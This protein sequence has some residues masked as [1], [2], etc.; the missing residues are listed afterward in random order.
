ME[1]FYWCF[2]RRTP[3]LIDWCSFL[4]LHF[5]GYLERERHGT[6]ERE[7]RG[8]EERNIREDNIK[9]NMV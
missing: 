9:G 8:M 7:R 6:D 4:S 2:E 1:S 3:W 5:A